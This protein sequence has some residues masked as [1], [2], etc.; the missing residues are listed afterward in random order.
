MA[1][2]EKREH[3]NPCFDIDEETMPSGVEMYV[4]GAFKFFN[5]V[6]RLKCLRNKKGGDIKK[7]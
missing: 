1:L 6:D 7:Q 2:F 5:N 3:H 4:K